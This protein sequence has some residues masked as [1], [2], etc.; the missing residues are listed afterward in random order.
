[1]VDPNHTARTN[2]QHTTVFKVKKKRKEK[3]ND[4]VDDDQ[5]KKQNERKMKKKMKIHS[6]FCCCCCL[7]AMLEIILKQCLISC[8]CVFFAFASR[9]KFS[10]TLFHI[11]LFIC[12]KYTNKSIVFFFYTPHHTL[13]FGI[14]CI[15]Y[16]RYVVALVFCSLN[17]T[18][19][20][21]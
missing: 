8:W 2:V 20:I 16:R 21:K 1:M 6:V 12:I 9:Q 5:N 18:L 14:S 10:F 17:G 11:H 3:S 7:D 4:E 15:L 13:L 19:S